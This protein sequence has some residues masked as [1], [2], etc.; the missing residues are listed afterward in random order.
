M[1][2]Q[3]M[4]NVVDPAPQSE[5]ELSLYPEKQLHEFT[6]SQPDAFDQAHH[7]PH[8]GQQWRVRHARLVQEHP[9]EPQDG[10]ARALV[11]R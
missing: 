5:A 1:L 4:Q 8:V 6:A 7:H 9:V 11:R 3:K 10:P 2:V